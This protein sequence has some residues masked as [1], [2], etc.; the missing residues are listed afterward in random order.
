[1][2]DKQKLILTLLF[3]LINL[4]QHALS[5]L[6]YPD[7]VNPLMIKNPNRAI[8]GQT[9]IFKFTLS[10]TSQGLN[11]GQV[12]GVDFPDYPQMNEIFFDNYETLFS[13]TLKDSSGIDHSV[14]PIKSEGNSFACQLNDVN[15][16]LVASKSY[17]LTIEVASNIIFSLYPRISC[18]NL[19]TATSGVLSKIYIDTNPCFADMALYPNYLDIS[20][21]PILQIAEIKTGPANVEV[22]SNFDLIVRLK[23]N[24]DIFLDGKIIVFKF[25]SSFG[26]PLAVNSTDTDLIGALPDSS[27]RNLTGALKIEPIASDKSFYISGIDKNIL[28]KKNT[29]IQITL[30]NIN[31]GDASM[32]NEKLQVYLYYK[33]SYSIISYDSTSKLTVNPIAL[34]DVKI[35][36]PD[37]FDV[38]DGSVSPLKIDFN[39]TNT[40][41]TGGYIVIK[42]ENLNL[43]KTKFN[44][45]ASTCDFSRTTFLS[46][47]FGERPICFPYRNTMEYA[48][49]NDDQA[50]TGIGSAIVFKLPQINNVFQR[51]FSI[52]LVV[53]GY[54]EI[55]GNSA[56]TRVTAPDVNLSKFSFSVKIYKTMDMSKFNENRFSESDVVASTPKAHIIMS[57]TC[58]GVSETLT[59]PQYESTIDTVLFTDIYDFRFASNFN[60]NSL[61]ASNTF[62][63]VDFTSLNN[64]LYATGYLSNQSDKNLITNSFLTVI[65]KLPKILANGEKFLQNISVPSKKF[66]DYETYLKGAMKVNFSKMFL[67]NGESNCY[68]SWAAVGNNSPTQTNLLLKTNDFSTEIKKNFIYFDSTKPNGWDSSSNILISDDPNA[69]LP[70]QIVSKVEDGTNFKFISDAAANSKDGG[71]YV[72]LYTSC[73]KFQSSFNYK[74]I[75]DYFEMSVNFFNEANSLVRVNRL[76]K[77]MGNAGLFDELQAFKGEVFFHTFTN[78]KNKILAENLSFYNNGICMIEIKA[79]HL[80]SSFGSFSNKLLVNISNLLL[81]DFDYTDVSTTYPNNNNLVAYANPSFPVTIGTRDYSLTTN[82]ITETILGSNYS[83]FKFA[84]QDFLFQTLGSS[85]IF[86]INSSNINNLKDILIPTS[87]PVF[88]SGNTSDMYIPSISI[89]WASMSDYSSMKINS[90]FADNTDTNNPENYFKM[91]S[92]DYKNKL[93][94]KNAGQFPI[95]TAIRFNQYL[96]QDENKLYVL[97]AAATA[98]NPNPVAFEGFT[99]TAFSLLMN[100]KIRIANDNSAAV[101]RLFNTVP[102][103]IYRGDFS[104]G[105]IYFYGI[106]FKSMLFAKAESEFVMANFRSDSKLSDAIYFT[107]LKR[108]LVTDFYDSIAKSY[109]YLNLLAFQCTSKGSEYYTSNYFANYDFFTPIDN[110]NLKNK[111]FILDSNTDTATTWSLTSFNSDKPNDTSYKRDLGGNI[112]LTLKTPNQIDLPS[113]NYLRVASSY[114]TQSTICGI[115][116]SSSIP[117]KTFP[118]SLSYNSG[119]NVYFSECLNPAYSQE[120]LICCYNVNIELDKLS[121]PTINVFYGAPKEIPNYTDYV[122][123]SQAAVVPISG[124]EYATGNSNAQDLLGATQSGNKFNNIQYTLATQE[125][126]FGKAN[127]SVTFAREIVRGS[128]IIINGDLSKLLIHGNLKPKCAVALT[129]FNDFVESCNVDLPIGDVIVITFKNNIYTCGINLPKSFNILIW[130]VSVF[131]YT[132]AASPS[133]SITM[134]TKSNRVLVNSSGKATLNF[135]GNALA[136]KV[137]LFQEDLC[138]LDIFPYIPGEVAD[139]TFTFDLAKNEKNIPSNSNLNEAL[140]Y[141]PFMLYQQKLTVL[142]SLKCRYR[143]ININSSNSNSNNF[144]D[145]NCALLDDNMIVVSFPSTLNTSLGNPQVQIIGIPNSYNN[146]NYYF[147]CTLNNYV[148]SGQKRTQVITGTGKFD[149]KL[150]DIDD[151]KTGGLDLFELLT[152]NMTPSDSGRITLKFRFDALISVSPGRFPKETFFVTYIPNE[153]DTKFYNSNSAVKGRI[154]EFYFDKDSYLQSKSYNIF[155]QEFLGNRLIIRISEETVLSENFSHCEIYLEGLINPVQS[156]D[157]TGRFRIVITNIFSEFIYKTFTNTGSVANSLIANPADDFLKFTKGIK[158]LFTQKK[159][160]LEFFSSEYVNLTKSLYVK[161]GRYIKYIIRTNINNQYD[162]SLTHSTTQILLKDSI[163]T[164]ELQ[165]YNFSTAKGYVEFYIGLPCTAIIPSVGN[166]YVNIELSNLQ[167]FYKFNPFII[168]V[169]EKLGTISTP[170]PI[171]DTIR[172]G[173]QFISFSLS[174][175]TFGAFTISFSQGEGAKNDASAT[176]EPLIFGPMQTQKT[177]VFKILSQTSTGFQ[178]FQINNPNVC[179]SLSST[180]IMVNVNAENNEIPANFKLENSLTFANS[181]MDSSLS[182][183]AIKVSFTPPVAPIFIYCSLVCYNRN[184]PNDDQLL[185]P[186]INYD[187]SDPLVQFNSMFI[188]VSFGRFDLVFNNLI[189]GMIYKLKC[190]ATTSQSQISNTFSVELETIKKYRKKLFVNSNI[191]FDTEYVIEKNLNGLEKLYNLEDVFPTTNEVAFEKVDAQIKVSDNVSTHCLRFGSN[192]QLPLMH[193]EKLLQYCQRQ[194]VNYLGCT[195]C[196]DDEKRTLPGMEF[197]NISSCFNNT[198]LNNANANAKTLRNMQI[199]SDYVYSDYFFN[200]GN[201]KSPFYYTVCAVQDLKCSYDI[202]YPFMYSE[203]ILKM[204]NDLKDIPTAR[205]TLG[206]S[207][208]IFNSLNI[209]YDKI[210]ADISFLKNKITDKIIDRN[211]NYTIKLNPEIN[212]NL[213]SIIYEMDLICFWK[214]DK[215]QNPPFYLSIVNC[216]DFAI[217]GSRRIYNSPVVIANNSTSADR[218]FEVATYNIWFVCFNNIPN[219]TKPTS[220]IS[221]M[222]FLITPKERL[223][224]ERNYEGVKLIDDK[225]FNKDNIKESNLKYKQNGVFT[226]NRSNMPDFIEEVIIV[227]NQ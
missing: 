67:Q 114:F 37:N 214:V 50:K 125:N 52:S 49:K 100:E 56:L 171:I 200:N 85:L 218:E 134:Q 176:M 66:D 188:P 209:Y 135:S 22:F 223:L 88:E 20:S 43:F 192:F 40:K 144:V 34:S 17:V 212:A 19:F 30:S 132:S 211:G 23:A 147:G 3:S 38:F 155:G 127:I 122:Y 145:T 31:V 207:D 68:F 191:F 81:L 12:V 184:Y 196:V 103:Y 199:I 110:S 167:N 116:F 96:N 174:D 104:K 157:T 140:I 227:N 83:K 5:D 109:N 117:V 225:G 95:Y 16:S 10:A 15:K 28:I 105:Q 165:I 158:Y 139:Y 102:A 92:S 221:L 51:I 129:G 166:Y 204:V 194:F 190:I 162:A 143:Q 25:P 14:S 62:N 208:F 2:K 74:S 8:G 63:N 9:F 7:Q 138:L 59:K 189:R 113:S 163:I 79:E 18:L 47:N 73:Y 202:D 141:F 65:I 58:F 205:N 26:N 94:E 108:P 39:I 197:S 124:S 216:N 87:C 11:Y 64:T 84:N 154:S 181:D 222:Q 121:F 44:F 177:S 29:N 219:P 164:T 119:S 76:F 150:I 178:N 169:D 57:H 220:V 183:N 210:P 123:T 142:E 24:S 46:Q 161:K 168:L 89:Y 172:A 128:Q 75:Y 187:N 224:Q 213:T 206:V 111:Y 182:K 1:M 201:L 97:P 185:N 32:L 160:Q 45:I 148:E 133:F 173:M 91:D 4:I 42:H 195:V 112:R 137:N 130:P 82:S 118:C 13:C 107:G 72:L 90:I 149:K 115:N 98:D 136:N 27:F 99:C 86:D 77:F 153:F 126:A 70:L 151:S 41:L 35:G 69:K 179:F 48:L 60:S 71:A 93:I 203:I 170:S 217:C 78:S 226:D 156:I 33:N 193:K 159:W 120:V 180:L 186:G 146:E 175:P 61:S 21:P 198:L 55:C 131:T 54:N 106:P 6:I 53:F 36:H 152:D 80:K 101:L 215:N